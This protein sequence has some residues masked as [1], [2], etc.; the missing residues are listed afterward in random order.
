MSYMTEQVDANGKPPAKLARP[1]ST[2]VVAA[3]YWRMTSLCIS[4]ESANWHTRWNGNATDADLVNLDELTQLKWLV[5]L[6]TQVTDAGL[7]IWKELTQ[8]TSYCTSRRA[9]Q[10]TDAGLRH[11]DGL[12]QL[13]RLYLN[14]TKVTDAGLNHLKGWTRLQWLGLCDTQVTD[15]GLKHLQGLTQLQALA[16]TALGLWT[17]DWNMS[18]AWPNS[19]TVSQLQSNY[20]CGAGTPRRL[21]PTP[22]V[23]PQRH[24]GHRRWREET[25]TGIAELH[26]FSLT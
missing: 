13:K 6:G 11:L 26:D 12:T 21:D 14:G 9:T 15:V 2:S 22:S 3:S 5:P 25:P 18:K 4:V 20:G 16:F 1:P 24:E 8:L 19:R 23:A 10:I 17:L 7:D